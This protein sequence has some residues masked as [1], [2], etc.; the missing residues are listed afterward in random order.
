MKCQLCGEE[1]ESDFMSKAAHSVLYHP[2]IAISA[3]QK[4]GVTEKA[5]SFGKTLGEIFLGKMK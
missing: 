5:E 4:H 2:D 3:M 1:V